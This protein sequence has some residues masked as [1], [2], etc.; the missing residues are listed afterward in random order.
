MGKSVL[1]LEPPNLDLEVY[2]MLLDQQCQEGAHSNQSDTYSLL[3][4][5]P[6]QVHTW[7]LLTEVHLFFFFLYFFI[8][9]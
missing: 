5:A 6:E 7:H 3:C 2:Q 9:F 8:Y 1:N 4:K